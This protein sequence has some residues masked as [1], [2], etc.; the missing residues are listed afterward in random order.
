MAKRKL[1][2]PRCDRSFSMAGHL[3]RHMNATHKRKKKKAAK[4]G[5]KTVGVARKKR[6]RQGKKRGLRRVGR[7]KGVA[8]RLGLKNMSL[9]QI[10]TL[11][12]AARQEARRR[13]ADLQRSFD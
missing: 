8:S 12:D 2:C 3:A 9:E 13:I 5:K 4:K 11:I 10:G 6:G 1:K 7:P